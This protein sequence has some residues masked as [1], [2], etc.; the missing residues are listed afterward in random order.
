LTESANGVAGLVQI[1]LTGAALCD[2]LAECLDL[3]VQV[4]IFAPQRFVLVTDIHTLS[5]RHSHPLH[6]GFK[7]V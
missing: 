5:N 3:R 7:H 2:A 4:C 6:S 1:D